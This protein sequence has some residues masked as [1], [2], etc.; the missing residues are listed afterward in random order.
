MIKRYSERL[1]E[2]ELLQNRLLLSFRTDDDDYILSVCRQISD[3]G[4][5]LKYSNTDYIFNYINCCSYHREP[6]F[7]V[8]GLLLSL[9]AKKNGHGIQII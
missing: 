2:L 9:Q 4:L 3:T 5:N 6:S 1:A 7:I 8:I